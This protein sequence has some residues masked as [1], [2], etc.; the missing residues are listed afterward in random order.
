M[1]QETDP[2][3]TA[4]AIDRGNSF[5][6]KTQLNLENKLWCVASPRVCV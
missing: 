3:G 2:V 6:S 5:G 4:C 1:F